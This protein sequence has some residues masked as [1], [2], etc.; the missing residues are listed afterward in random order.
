MHTAL[1]FGVNLTALNKNTLLEN[2]GLRTSLLHLEFVVVALANTGERKAKYGDR[3]K[4]NK[5]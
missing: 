4:W 3:M 5:T 2:N 1:S